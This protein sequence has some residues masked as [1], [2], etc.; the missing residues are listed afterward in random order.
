VNGWT[1]DLSE[2]ARKELRALDMGAKQAAG[3]L[4]AE[5]RELGSALVLSIR[6]RAYK[7]RLESPFSPGPVPDDLSGFKNS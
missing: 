4:I 7:R 6:M 3:E 5:L 1:V 2:T